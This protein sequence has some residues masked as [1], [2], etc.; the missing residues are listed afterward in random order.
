MLTMIMINFFSMLATVH[1]FTLQYAFDHIYPYR[2]IPTV[3]DHTLPDLTVLDCLTVLY[4]TE[5]YESVQN[6]TGSYWTFLYLTV[7]NSTRT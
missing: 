5:P 7:L 4:S 2:T 3:L 1:F 6:L